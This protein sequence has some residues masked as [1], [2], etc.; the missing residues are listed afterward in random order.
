MSS[1]FGQKSH[2]IANQNFV[3]NDANFGV[4]LGAYLLVGGEVSISVDLKAWNDELI[5]IFYESMSYGQ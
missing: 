2:C 3:S 4:S 5:S 1:T